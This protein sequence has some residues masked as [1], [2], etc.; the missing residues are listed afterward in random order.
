MKRSS[1]LIADW[2]FIWWLHKNWADRTE[3]L[4][5]IL[6]WGRSSLWGL[7]GIQPGSLTPAST[8][9]PMVSVLKHPTGSRRRLAISILLKSSRESE[10]RDRLSASPPF[11]EHC[12]EGYLGPP[13]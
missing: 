13:P 2:R 1:E 4:T 11:W 5:H 7:Y 10:P 3:R 8:C 6:S 12:P 9:W